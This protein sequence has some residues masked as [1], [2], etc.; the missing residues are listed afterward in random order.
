MFHTNKFKSAGQQDALDVLG[1]E[2]FLG[3]AV[4][5]LAGD[6][7]SCLPSPRASPCGPLST[8]RALETAPAARKSWNVDASAA[9]C[10]LSLTDGGGGRVSAVAAGTCSLPLPLLPPQRV[11]GGKSAAA[12]APRCRTSQR[13]TLELLVSR[14]WWVEKEVWKSL[15]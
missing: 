7:T 5:S 4:S 15:G 11:G 13:N 6:S 10:L 12:L 2:C 3:S 1:T 9:I 14:C 8:L